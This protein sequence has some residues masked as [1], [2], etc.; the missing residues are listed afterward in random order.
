MITITKVSYT[1]RINGEHTKIM[2]AKRGLCQGVPLTSMMFD[3]V[4]DYLHIIF[5]RIRKNPNFNYHS[6]CEKLGI[7]ILSFADNLLMFAIEDTI[8]IELL[9]QVFEIFSNST[10]LVANPSKYKIYYGNIDI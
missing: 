5:Q 7:I 4:M 2:K 3:L 9:M 6:K 1:Y 10:G 8:S